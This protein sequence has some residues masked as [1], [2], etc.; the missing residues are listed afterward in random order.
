M[1][2]KFLDPGFLKRW[3]GEPEKSVQQKAK[4]LDNDHNLGCKFFHET[5]I[6][7]YNC[8]KLNS[9]NMV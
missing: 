3:R 2:W 9:Y 6:L 7:S 5:N 1:F 4:H 8:Y